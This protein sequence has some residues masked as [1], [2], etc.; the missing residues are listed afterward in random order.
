M[1]NQYSN[2]SWA[3]G[4]GEAYLVVSNGTSS[5][6]LTKSVLGAS[7]A[8]T[9]CL[10]D[11]CWTIT[12]YD[13]G[14][15]YLNEY[16]WDVTIAGSVVASGNVNSSSI[17]GPSAQFATGSGFCAIPGCIDSTALNYDPLATVD[18]SSC[19][20]PAPCNS[21]TFCDDFESG[22]FTT[23]NWNVT[24]AAQSDVTVST[25]ALTGTYSAQFEGGM[26]SGWSGGST[27]TTSAQAW[28]NT[29]HISSIDMCADLTTVSG[30][31]LN[32]TLDYNSQSIFGSGRYSYFRVLVNGVAI[33]DAAGNLD[34]W[35]PGQ[36]TLAYDLSAY[37]CLLYTSP[38][39]GDRG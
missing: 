13:G 32:M 9:L 35:A 31:I 21:E 20:Y 11:D 2:Y 18:D 3:Q 27:S 26:S 7:L 15:S 5:D 19:V 39:P 23:G 8:H 4:L 25:N 36:Q 37:I 33:A 6:T 17:G 10:A 22:S 12:A 1:Y 14:A 30:S 28:G 34:Y 29:S 24:T 38:S 16:S